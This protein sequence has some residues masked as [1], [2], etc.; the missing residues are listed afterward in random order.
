MVS[1]VRG[2]CMSQD[3]LQNSR[4]RDVEK[5]INELENQMSAI[6]ARLDTVMNLLKVIGVGCG[7]MIGI[8]VQGM[9]L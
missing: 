6:L 7:A 5:R 1:R 9:V 2:I 8:D 4:I 3:D